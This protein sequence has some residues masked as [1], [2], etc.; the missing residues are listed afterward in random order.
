MTLPMSLALFDLDNTL[1]GG[2][3]DYLW[4]RFLAE[5]GHVDGAENERCHRRYYQDYLDGSL[6]IH[7]FLGFQLEVLG[8]YEMDT[9][10]GWRAQFLEEKIRPIVLPK[11]VRLVEDHRGRGDTLLIITATN[12][13]LTAPIAALFDVPHLIATEP[14]WVDGRYSG[15]A[16]GTPS[17]AG[18]KVARLAAW[19]AEHGETLTD[20]WCYSDSHNDLPLLRAATHPVAVDPDAPLTAAA[21][22]HGWPIISLR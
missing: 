5:Q 9:L 6:D 13:F 2:D 8:K 19:L 17:F 21:R 16:I 10:S 15:R 4:G 11:A 1:I 7:E 3:S 20:S 14:E 12:R 22:A 18:G